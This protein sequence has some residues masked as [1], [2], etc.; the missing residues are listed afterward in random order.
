MR[1]L[2]TGVLIGLVLLAIDARLPAQAGAWCA[3]LPGGKDCGFD[4]FEQ[5]MVSARSDNGHCYR[6]PAAPAASTKSAQP[7]R[8][9][10]KQQQQ[11]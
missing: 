10:K 7:E 2:A 11:Q 1:S 4:T 8:K 3:A 5:C 9:S 6:N